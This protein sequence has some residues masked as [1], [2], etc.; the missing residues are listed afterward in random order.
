MTAK[1]LLSPK[2]EG[3][4][5]S[6]EGQQVIIWRV[7]QLF[8]ARYGSIPL[9]QLL[10]S[11][12]TVVL[13]ELGRA[14]TVTELC[15]ATGLPKSSISRYISAAMEQDMVSETIDSEDRRR[16]MLGQ[17]ENGKNERRWQVREIRKILEETADWDRQ[18]ETAGGALDPEAELAAM[19]QVSA[20]PPESVARERKKGS[21]E[22]A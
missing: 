11:M 14:P 2:L 20:N 6:A 17:T 18:R 9:G 15:D 19:I 13:N 8:L 5:P 21:Q 22:A 1:T 3:W 10:V 4:T 12:T 7:L 16:R